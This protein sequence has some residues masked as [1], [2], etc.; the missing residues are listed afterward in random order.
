LRKMVRNYKKLVVA[1]LIC[2]VAGLIGSFF[3]I[4]SVNTWYATIQKPSFNPP[5][6]VFG[7]VWTALYILMGLSA[8][9]VWM[10]GWGRK[11]VRSALA[12]FGLQLVLNV[13]WSVIFF[14]AKQLFYSFV[15]IAFL[16]LSIVLTILLFYKISKNAALLLV[17]YLLWVSF[18][19]FLNYSVW[20]MNP[21]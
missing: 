14:G 12:V 13:L 18:A 11:D 6:W 16:W 8:Y 9:L 21:M 7:P 19:A 20:Q 15:E 1:V 5:N 3:T 4:N 10:K 17:P 2:L